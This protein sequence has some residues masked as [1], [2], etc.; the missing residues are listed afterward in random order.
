MNSVI[1]II[2]GNADIPN[3]QNVLFT[4]L[5]PVTTYDIAV[6]PKP[7]FF[8]GANLRDIDKK[9]RDKRDTNSLYSLIIPTKHSTFPVACNFFL[10]AKAPSGGAH[11][12]R[13]QACYDGAF[14][15]RT[16]HSL[17]NY[18]FDEPVYDGN[19]YTFSA[20][21]H[22]GTGTLQLYAHHVTAPTTPGGRPEYHM[23]QLRT[24]GMTDTRE[25]FVGGA[26][27]FRN[28]RDLAEDHRNAFIATANERARQSGQVDPAVT[29]A[30]QQDGGSSPDE[31]VDC[32]EYLA[33][34]DV[35]GEPSAPPLQ[36]S[37]VE[38]GT[39]QDINEGPAL[40]PNAYPDDDQDESQASVLYDGTEE[41]AA[42]YTTSFTSSF[43]SS[44]DTHGHRNRSKRQNSQSPPS[45]P[46][47]SKKQHHTAQS[48]HHSKSGKKDQR[49]ERNQ[50]AGSGKAKANA[51][52]SN[53]RDTDAWEWD[54]KAKEHK[55]W[56]AARRRWEYWDEE[57]QARKHWDGEE[58]QWVES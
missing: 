53:A 9:V 45:S 12:L 13:R 24:F 17:Q 42:S 29:T 31:F 3:Q 21:Y 33:S 40:L 58:W 6:K 15:A 39:S 1:P 44:N 8:D 22:A 57:Y 51:P 38:F 7:D 43:I 26:T 11:V 35:H 52:L 36:Q 5:E 27:A 23:T 46:H 47:H 4:E 32:E 18:G 28:L 34:Q 54:D 41:P 50:P 14:G 48:G 2:C 49:S 37:S 19:A 55:T 30:A 56:N 25:T 16:M 20:T 10:E